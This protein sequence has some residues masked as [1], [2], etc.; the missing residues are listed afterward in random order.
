MVPSGAFADTFTT[1]TEQIAC[2]GERIA[3]DALYLYTH[4]HSALVA[5]E[6]DTALSKLEEAIRTAAINA[7][8]DNAKT[9]L[10]YLSVSTGKIKKMLHQEPTQERLTQILDFCDGLSE[11]V[12]SILPPQTTIP[13][14][15][16]F[17]LFLNKTLRAY[18]AREAHLE[19]SSTTQLDTQIARIDA[20]ATQMDGGS[21]R[22]WRN[23]RGLL[24]SDTHIPTLV[25]FAI[26]DLE[27]R[28]QP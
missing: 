13:N 7:P 21:L 12:L 1:A 28:F 16:R 3:T 10:E 22:L 24:R 11:G 23:C 2:D 8:D 27:K 25:T 19:H 14:D 5:H 17:A 9:V 20:I 15:L 6:M 18:L 26:R 4:P